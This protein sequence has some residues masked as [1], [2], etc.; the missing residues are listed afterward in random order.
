MK[1]QFISCIIL[2]LRQIHQS[3]KAGLNPEWIKYLII[4][5]HTIALITTFPLDHKRKFWELGI[6]IKDN[7]KHQRDALNRNYSLFTL[8]NV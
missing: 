4:F 5:V 3:G 2:N 8:G 7:F 1:F 6:F